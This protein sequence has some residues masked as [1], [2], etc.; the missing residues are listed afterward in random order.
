MSLERDPA[1]GSKANPK[2][3]SQMKMIHTAKTRKLIFRLA[4]GFHTV[5]NLYDDT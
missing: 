3:E 5:Y 4:K 2:A 1:N